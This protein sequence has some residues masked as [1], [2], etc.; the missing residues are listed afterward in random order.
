MMS[1]GRPQGEVTERVEQGWYKNDEFIVEEKLDGERMQL[2][3]VGKQYR[4]YSR[5]VTSRRV[6][7]AVRPISDSRASVSQESKRV[8]VPL[9]SQRR[10][11]IP[12]S[13]H[14]RAPQRRL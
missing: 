14:R 9:R 10:W 7:C 8:H 3:K 4:Y 2:H 1:R 5:F 11:W 13:L 12:H 6:E